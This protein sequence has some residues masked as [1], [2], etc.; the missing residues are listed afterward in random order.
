MARAYITIVMPE[1]SPGSVFAGYV[2]E[3]VAGEGGMGIVYRATHLVLARSV[4]LKVIR[5]EYAKDA[6]FRVRFLSESKI[7]AAI[8]HPHVIPVDNAGEEDGVLFLAMR[9]VTGA[10][11]G[12]LIAQE[13]RV[14]P[15]RAI[16]IVEQVASALDA[17]HHE[18]LVHR[19]VKPVNV[20]VAARG[21]E[22]AY[23][24]DFGLAKH[25]ESLGGLTGPG[26]FVG[27]V[28]Y[29]PPE[30]IEGEH[31]LDCRA[32]VYALGG[33]LFYA[34]A[35]RVPYPK[36]NEV[37]KAY[38]HLNDPPPSLEEVVSDSP[39]RLGE[40]I[41][42][43]M[44]KDPG[45]RYPSAGDLARAARSALTDT[46]PVEPERSVA[47]GPAAPAATSTA[48]ATPTP[49][50]LDGLIAGG[51]PDDAMPLG[52]GEPPP[53]AV[54]RTVQAPASPRGDG[55]ATASV[56]APSTGSA[57]SD[58]QANAVQIHSEDRQADRE[59][60]DEPRPAPGSQRSST[61]A[62]VWLPTGIGLLAAAA[63]LAPAGFLIG[64]S[65]SGAD[66]VAP[67][68]GSASTGDL[69]VR[70]PSEWR[71]SAEVPEL[72]GIELSRAIAVAPTTSDG[73]GLVAGVSAATGAALLSRN[74][75]TRL[76]RVPSRDQVLLGR[77]EAYR[78]NSLR[79]RRYER[80][81][82]VFVAPT[83]LGVVTVACYYR[84]A[85]A[86]TFAAECGR[87]ARTLELTRGRGYRLGPSRDYAAKLNAA[88]KP[89]NSTG[90]RARRRLRSASTAG[91]QE[92]AASDLSEAFARAGAIL[93]RGGVSPADADVNARIVAS[94]EDTSKAYA[95]TAIAARRGDGAAYARAVR[96]VRAGERSLRR[97]RSALAGRG[98]AVN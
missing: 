52:A 51:K 16:R 24:T 12:A 13:G 63:V 74:L 54:P 26:M 83:T 18:G 29:A 47:R 3:E 22:H 66:A 82:T 75:T 10:D 98:Y 11:L 1:F 17:A 53:H 92:S 72:P 70:F 58:R 56:P 88:L 15:E 40:V 31:R 62:R 49:P 25:E 46:H 44:A 95:R 71:R 93:R 90:V 19:D 84:P 39:R 73:T 87:V 2:I 43:A 85:D 96:R 60:L 76:D 55:V 64:R 34:V 91:R 27:T 37:A 61:F 65:G 38:A 79:P 28:D 8:D 50:P 33:L 68:V 89:L 97:A 9:Y 81:L 80:R 78:Y 57:P 20:L 86:I 36:E 32:D 7:A 94:L 23:L 48:P 14:Q 45:E 59:G 69:E 6:D 67:L 30:Q 42:R 21:Q 41:E 77:L 35:G 5:P 4:A